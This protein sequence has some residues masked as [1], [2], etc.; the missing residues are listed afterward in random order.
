MRRDTTRLFEPMKSRLLVQVDATE[1]SLTTS[2]AELVLRHTGPVLWLALCTERTD[3][4]RS[5]AE[6]TPAFAHAGPRRHGT[7]AAKTTDPE[8]QRLLAAGAFAASRLRCPAGEPITDA[9]FCTRLLEEYSEAVFI[10]GPLATDFPADLRVFVGTPTVASLHVPAP[11]ASRPFANAAADDVA[12]IRDL[13]TSLLAEHVSPFGPGLV[14]P[15]TAAAE[16]DLLV[17]DARDDHERR[18]AAAL[19]AEFEAMRR[20]MLRSRPRKAHVVDLADPKHP[21]TKRL[22]AAVKRAFASVR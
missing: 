11:P 1:P 5:F 9:V 10:T 20:A 3:T 21:G 2:F 12:T 17:L 15:F 22:L 7:R 14:P 16:A 4:R 18:Q 6:T 19:G 8:L 13:L